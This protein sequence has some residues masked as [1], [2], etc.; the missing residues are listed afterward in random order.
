M[1]ISSLQFCSLPDPAVPL[2]VFF[3]LRDFS[4][5]KLFPIS[6]LPVTS[7]HIDPVPLLPL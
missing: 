1:Y 3:N 2:F 4:R 5:I 7:I 6:G